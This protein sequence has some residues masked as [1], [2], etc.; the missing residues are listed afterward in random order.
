MKTGIQLLRSMSCWSESSGSEKPTIG[1]P[2][3]LKEQVN[4][5]NGE[6]DH[7]LAMQQ[8]NS[9]EVALGRSRGWRE[10]LMTSSKTSSSF[11]GSR[12]AMS[13]DNCR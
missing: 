13:P 4:V 7:Y 2:Q 12:I 6:E 8:H 11:G 9:I 3:I 5:G 10:W 1:S